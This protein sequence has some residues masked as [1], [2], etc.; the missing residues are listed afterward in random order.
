MYLKKVN[1]IYENIQKE[2]RTWQKIKNLLGTSYKDLGKKLGNTITDFIFQE[3]KSACKYLI[4]KYFP[5]V[6]A[7]Q[8]QQVIDTCN[9]EQ[10]I[11]FNDT[12]EIAEIN[13][14]YFCKELLKNI[15]VSSLKGQNLQEDKE[16][17]KAIKQVKDEEYSPFYDVKKDNPSQ[18][19]SNFAEQCI[20][21]YGIQQ[22]LNQ[23]EINPI[24]DPYKKSIT[25]NIKQIKLI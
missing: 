25:H 19:G 10:Q 16:L 13:K 17:D 9:S 5:K 7:A 8:L 18:K 21:K 24:P 14:G 23:L 3:T 6:K 20:S 12:T 2:G 4:K 1:V 15:C 22:K 11:K